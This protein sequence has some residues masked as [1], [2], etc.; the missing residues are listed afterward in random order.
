M[1]DQIVSYARSLFERGYVV[2]SAGNI[3]GTITYG[4]K[5]ATPTRI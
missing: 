2:G 5:L 3:S 4:T 1:R